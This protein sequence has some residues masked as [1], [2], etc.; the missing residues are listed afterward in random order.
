MS[1]FADVRARSVGESANSV[2]IPTAADLPPGCVVLESAVG[3]GPFGARGIGERV[4]A[5]ID[6]AARG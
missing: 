6:A 1:G 5:C 2:V 4:L 3:M